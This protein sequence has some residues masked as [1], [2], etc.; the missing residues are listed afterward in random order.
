[1]ISAGHSVRVIT[2]SD[3][4]LHADDAYT[5]PVRRIERAGRPLIL[6]L[7]QTCWTI[8]RAAVHA[9]VI[10]AN[11]LNCEV[12]I[13]GTIARVPVVAK[14]VGDRAWE[15]ARGRGWF[16]G[17]IEEYQIAPKPLRLRLLDLIRTIPLRRSTALIVP[18]RYLQR[19]VS[20]WWIDERS[21]QVVYNAVDVTAPPKDAGRTQRRATI[22]TVARLVAWKHIDSL[23]LMLREIEDARL[24]IVGDGPLR[25]QLEALVRVEGLAE[26][27][28]F[29][30]SVPRADVLSA[31]AGADVF[32]LNSSYE[33]LP[34]VVLEAMACG[35]PVVATNVGGTGE[36]VIDGETGLLIP[37]HDDIALRQAVNRIL[38]EPG[39]AARLV[40]GAKHRL[41]QHHSFDAMISAFARVLRDGSRRRKDA[42]VADPVHR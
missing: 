21:I 27:I 29:M 16:E 28:T 19:L 10:L 26:R 5:F 32:V 8:W 23:I 20:G 1:M 42:V 4:L 25:S 39:L 12:M 33:G 18:S 2:L 38:S 35:T 14:V 11:G 13:A 24:V 15:R 3:S 40:T 22:V 6:R 37:P 31:V 30:G 7:L 36:V 17:S 41:A 34:H 9:D